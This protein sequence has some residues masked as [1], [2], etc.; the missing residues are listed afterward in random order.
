MQIHEITSKKPVNEVLGKVAGLAA[1]LVGG[2]AK[3]AG[4]AYL[5][6]VAPQMATDKVGAP[7][8]RIGGMAVTQQLVASLAPQMQKAWQQTVQAFL[9][10]SKDSLGNPA[11]RM[12]DV[13]SPS[14]DN[15]KAELIKMVNKMISPGSGAFDYRNLD[16]YVGAD[17]GATEIKAALDRG[18]LELFS[19]T[20]EGLSPQAMLMSFQELVR[21]GIAPAQNVM[22]YDRDAGSGKKTRLYKDPSGR[23]VIDLGDGPEY[24][25]MA[26]PAHKRAWEEYSTGTAST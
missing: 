1:N 10:N 16:R 24:F 3:Q 6:K 12:A 15:L 4:Q 2:I 26:N 9:A 23:T 13:T 8:D 14:K 18:I 11:T 20:V 25:D 21:D 5:Q 7:T 19:N 17:K 22:A